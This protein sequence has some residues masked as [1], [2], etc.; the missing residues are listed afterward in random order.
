MYVNVFE[1]TIAVHFIDQNINHESGK[2]DKEEA[3]TLCQMDL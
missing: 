1:E 3:V 2:Y